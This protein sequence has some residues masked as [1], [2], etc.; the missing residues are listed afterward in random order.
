VR[1]WCWAKMCGGQL[2]EGEVYRNLCRTVT[3]NILGFNYIDND[4]YH[5]MFHLREDSTGIVL[6]GDIGIHMIEL[7]KLREVAV[8]QQRKLVR[9]TRFL[10]GRGRE[11]MEALAMEQPAIQRSP[12]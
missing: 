2:V 11:K 10:V 8:G 3:I 5:N 4:R 1:S 6:T 12:A 7:Q 9:W